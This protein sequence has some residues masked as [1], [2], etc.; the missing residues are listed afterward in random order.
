MQD[1]AVSSQMD[2]ELAADLARG[3]D[4]DV[5]GLPCGATATETLDRDGLIRW[6]ADREDVPLLSPGGVQSWFHD[7]LP[8][9]FMS[10]EGRIIRPPDNV[11]FVPFNPPWLYP[12]EVLPRPRDD[13]FITTALA[14]VAVALFAG[15]QNWGIDAET[16]KAAIVGL[17]VIITIAA[18]FTVLL[19]IVGILNWLDHRREEVE[20]TDEAVRPGF[21]RPPRVRNF[22]RWH[23]TYV[24]AF[25]VTSVAG[26]WVL[27]VTL[28]LPA[29]G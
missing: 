29:I 17:M 1:S 5:P 26:M 16:A 10:F 20:L 25:V 23:E 6:L 27:T 15:H 2:R 19:I 21:R 3:L 24:V 9:L 14:G 8:P 11:L 13:R 12:E 18:G 4:A 7:Q 22:V 28:L